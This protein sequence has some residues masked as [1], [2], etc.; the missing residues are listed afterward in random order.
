MHIVHVEEL[1]EVC[2]PTRQLDLG[3]DRV[4]VDVGEPPY[5]P[6]VLRA[7]EYARDVNEEISGADHICTLDIRQAEPL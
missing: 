1:T 3:E 7:L 2:L 5:L 6:V 4:R